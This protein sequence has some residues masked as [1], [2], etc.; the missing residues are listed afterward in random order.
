MANE[1]VAKNG[2]IAKANSAITGTLDVSG[3]ITMGTAL[4]ATRTWVTSTALSGYATE[5]YVTTAINNLIDAAPGTLD[6]LNELAAALGDDPNFA[7]TVTNS[8]AGKVSKA[9]DTMTGS[10]QVNNKIGTTDNQGIF[11]RGVSDVTHKIYFRSS[12]GGNVW[13]YNSPIKFEYYNLGT[14]TTRL[15]LTEAGNLIVTGTLSASGYNNTNWDTAYN[16]RITAASVSGTG[17]KTLTLTQGDGTTL[18]ATWVDYDTDTDAQTLTW[19]AG[20]KMLGISGGNDITLDGLATEEFVTG[21]GY[22]TFQP[23]NSGTGS[24]NYTAGNVGIGTTNPTRGLTINRSGQYAALNIIKSNTTNQIVY[25]GTGSSGSD[26]DAIL[27]MFDEATEKV[28]IF[29]AGN[30]WFN[31]GNVGIGTTAPEAKLHVV[32]GASEAGILSRGSSGDTWFPY[33]NGNNYIRGTTYF[34]NAPAYFTGGNVGIGTTSPSEKLHVNGAAIFDGGAGDSSTDSVLYVT[35]SNNNDWGLYVNASGLDYGMYT[36][37]S[38]TAEYAFAIH[39]GSTWTTRIT[40][41]G[42]VYLG[43][44]NAIEGASDS[45]LRLN[46]QGHYTSGVYTPARLRNDGA[47]ENYGGIYGYATIRGRKAQTDNNYTTAALWTE[48]YDGTTTGIAF[49]I[50]GNVGKFLEMRTDGVLYWENTPVATRSW[51]QAQGYLTSETDS[52]TL[53]WDGVSKNLTIT[54]GNTVT[55]DGLLTSEDIDGYGFLTAE[56]D[57]LQSVTSRGSSTNTDISIGG[58]GGD[59]GLAIYHTDYGRIRFYQSSTNI[60]TIHS[61]GTSWAGGD[62]FASGG[63]INITGNTGVTFGGWNIPDVVFVNGGTSYFRNNVGIGTTSPAQKLDVNGNILTGTDNFT[64]QNGGW[65]FNGNGSYTNGIFASSSSNNLTLRAPQLMSFEAGGAERMLING[66]GNVGIG[67]EPNQGVRLQVSGAVDVWNSLNTLLRLNH[68]GTSGVIESYTGGGYASTVLNP[69]GGNVGIGTTSPAQKLHVVGTNGSIQVGGSGYT[70]NPSGML[71]GQYVSGMGYI[72]APSGGRVE[73]WNAA[74]ENIVNFN[75]D[76]SSIFYGNVGIGTSDFADISFGSNI[77]KVYGS[78]ATLGL[79]STGSLATI[80][81]ISNSDPSKGIHL[82]QGSDGSFRWYQYSVGGE[83]F[84]LAADGNVGINAANP[85]SKLQVGGNIDATGVISQT[86]WTNDSIRKLNANASLNFR[87]AAGPI[88]MVLDGSGN[89]V[90][91]GISPNASNG[92]KIFGLKSESGKYFTQNAF[93]QDG[94]YTWPSTTY[95]TGNDNS[96]VGNTTFRGNGAFQGHIT[97]DYIPIDATKTYKVSVWMRAVTGSPFCYLS[98]RQYYWD[99]S[100]GNPGNG[101]WGN[102]YWF[103]GTPSSSWTEYSMTIGPAG[104]GADYTHMAGVKFIRHGWLHN[105]TGDGSA[106]AEFQGWKVE[107]LDSILAS[108]V[109]VMG[110]AVATQSWVTSQGYLTSETDSQNLEWDGV[111]K[112]LTITNGN[113]VTLDGLLTNEDLAAYGY[114]SS[115]S[116]T[117]ATVT[118][119]GASTSSTLTSTSQLGLYVNSGSAS[120]IGM[121]STSNWAYVSLLNNGSTTW[122]IGAY[123]GGVLEFRPYGGNNNVMSLALDGSLSINSFND[124]KLNLRVPSG[125]SS[126][127]NY[128]NFTGSNGVRDAYLGTDGGGNPTWWRD[129]NGVNITLGSSVLIN[130]NTAWHS[131]NDGSG[132]GLDADTVDGIHASTFATRQDGARYSTDVNSLMSSGFYNVEGQPANSPVSYGQIIVAKGIDTAFQI[133]GGYSNN[134][135]YFRGQGYGPESGGFYPWRRVWHNDDF[136]STNISNWN[137]AY[138]WGN[139]ADAS[140]F[141]ADSGEPITIQ[142]E[143][144]TFTGNVEVQGTFTETSSIRFKENIK[145]LEPVLGK[146]EELNPVTY[147]KIGLEDEEIGLIAEEVA[148]LFPEVVTYNEEGLATGVQYQRLS[149]ILLKAVQELTERVNKLENK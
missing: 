56:S 94:G 118:G 36:R 74:T 133:A 109:T 97:A 75:N 64:A 43:E 61:F 49:H 67:T 48:S 60:S 80:A 22:T 2:I 12:D 45:W 44:K 119:R 41:S 82:N 47:F 59:R 96:P 42:V 69:N 16:D 54:N 90:V 99:Y 128:I 73:I 122:D 104:S 11:L 7:T 35:K 110:S 34:D 18:T 68:D 93:G 70:L 139:H 3:N 130:G 26:D 106:T 46:N 92:A 37:V 127:W 8:I 113:T 1:F 78:R 14:P 147:N 23:W 28:R 85:T 33:T 142:A 120:Y 27:Q 148:E 101:G 86:F 17:T 105:Y 145:T 102:P 89:L 9:G 25:L 88:E 103:S 111:S 53:E 21:Q 66:S 20:S 117:L 38:P 149:V 83:T 146:V 138:S 134:A 129:D 108:N 115:E 52:Q 121:N 55:L 24:I 39:N 32:S 5:S 87:A 131:G 84:S 141:K 76:R 29:T 114:I 135:L 137:A 6:T 40:G 63:A 112:N 62:V 10:L 57:T 144:V 71:I 72:Q 136:S 31:G 4:V 30:S 50:S 132:S 91:G 98:H 95:V 143:T 65:F 81:L 13:E 19:E 77:L 51:V 126:E 15:T 58:T 107:E 124:G 140:Y 116:D 125:D 123:N 100:N 79:T